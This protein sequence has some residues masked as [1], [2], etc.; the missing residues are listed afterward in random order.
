MTRLS[1]RGL[2][3]VLGL[4]G[5]LASCTPPDTDLIAPSAAR[6]GMFDTYVAIGNSITAGFQSSGI[7]DSTQRRSYA[8]LLAQ[9][10]GTRFAYPQ[11]A[12]RGCPPLVANFQTQAGP[13]TI[14][15]T[16]RPLI[17][18]LR[19]ASTATDILNNVAV[20]GAWS[21]DPTSTST[22]NSN[23]LT[24]FFLG[25]KTQVERALVA[26][27]TFVSVWIGNNDLLGPAISSGGTSTGP[28][29]SLNAITLQA[30]FET[31]YNA[32]LDTLMAQNPNL[33]GVLVGVV[34]VSNAPIMFPASAF[35]SALFKAG[36]DA[37]AGTPTVLDASCTPTGAGFTSLIN[38]FLAFQIRIGAHPAIVACVPRGA[39]GALPFPVG[40]ALVLHASEQTTITNAVNAYNAFDSTKANAL[41]FA[42]VNPN[43]I[44]VT[45]KTG[46]TVIRSV[47]NYGSTT[48]PFGTGMS[49]D[50]VHPAA[51]VHLTIANEIIAAINTKYSIT[52]PSVF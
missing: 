43:P 7:T 16:A 20:P 42:W 18:D 11:I 14:T 1:L 5:I 15:A 19:S 47:P 44:L 6:G 50:G 12:G 49:L 35:Q 30:T 22:V 26:S 33:K 38:T 52:L 9:S 8:F 45:L 39:S 34:N 13:G 31:N 4:A 10:F 24:T 51:A 25:G 40:D 2:A 27:P 41:G 21:G 29:P 28:A 36:F 17:C 3:T 46:G 48:Q 37:I 23:A 32:I